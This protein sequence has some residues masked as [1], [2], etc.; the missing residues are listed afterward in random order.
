MT[1]AAETLP[2]RLQSIVDEAP[3]PLDAG[4]LARAWEY[5]RRAHAG[6]SRASGAP[7][8]EHPLA[9]AAILAD[10]YADTASLAAAL[11]HDTVEDT[12]ADLE[13][14]ASE[15]G[16]EVAVLVDGLTKIR[17]FEL[18]AGADR[19]IETYRKLILST[20]EDARVLLIKLADR[21]HNMRTLDAL[22]EE[23]R[24]RIARETRG[25]YAPM[26]HRLGMHRVKAELED[27]AFRH[28]EPEQ[29]E[30]VARKVAATRDARESR[31]ADFV[32]PLQ[33]E[34]EEADV[35][36]EINGRAKHLWSIYRKMERRE[37]PFEEIYDAL[38]V[39]V[40][41]E[42]V[43]DCYHAL[44][45]VHSQWS[46]ITEQ[47]D[48]YIARPKS[49]LYRSLHTVVFGP[50]DRRYEVQI[51]TREMHETAEY[52]IAA[53][54][55]YK[56]G[57]RGA[58]EVDEKLTWFRRVL[59]WQQGTEDP[60][61]FLEFLKV[62]LFEEEIFVFTPQ[63]DVQELRDGSTALDFAFAIHTEVGLRARG[64][65]IDGRMRPLDHELE[66]GD[67][68]EIVTDSGQ[69]PSRD[70]LE[71]A[72]TSKA[73]HDIRKWLREQEQDHALEI[74]RGVLEEMADERGAALPADDRLA[75]VAEELGAGHEASSLV[76]ALGRNDVSRRRVSRRLFGDSDE[77][78]QSPDGRSAPSGSES[79]GGGGPERGQDAVLEGVA[80][81]MVSY[82]GCCQPVPGDEIVG[83]VTRGQGVTVHRRSCPNYRA[84]DDREE[85][86]VS[87]RWPSVEGSRHPA[88]VRF[89][90]PDR[91]GLLADVARSVSQSGTN[92]RSAD[93]E[94]GDGW[95]RGEL[96]V[97]VESRRHLDELVARV[98]EVGGV[99]EARRVGD[100][101]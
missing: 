32:D 46:P 11:L 39:R 85:R 30:R 59:E 13:E 1:R 58:S 95:A 67:A 99:R 27:L 91:Q 92:I 61:E 98:R 45:L 70:W 50:G 57:E 84:L 52:G 15:F 8:V 43:H 33:E 87:V 89:E 68:V 28:L 47:F 6:Q 17:H 86:E 83:Y 5:A 97:D 71:F 48:D 40:I 26:A 38:A 101:R 90:G 23:R 42:S 82:A 51:R 79:G 93:V 2:D 65:K 66:S 80:D 20:A 81:L 19:Q 55:R 36:A 53:H 44:G 10:F 100:V 73:R 9:V 7:Y 74:G 18:P 96:V 88:R 21:L 24:R 35:D 63:G 69:T 62:D 4:L 54:W 64:A 56:E 41:V 49:N 25:F 14:I 77:D 12:D 76:S 72:V 78:D 75:E 94:T 37:V 29:W 22:E 60:E 31:I 3:A 16:T 34:L